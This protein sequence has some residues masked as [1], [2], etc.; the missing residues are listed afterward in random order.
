MLI[1]SFRFPYQNEAQDA[2]K[3]G[4]AQCKVLQ[5]IWSIQLVSLFMW[6]LAL[7]LQVLLCSYSMIQ[8]R[9]FL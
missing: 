3:T 2:S 4:A 1:T 7:T 9:A 8:L 6:S 5:N